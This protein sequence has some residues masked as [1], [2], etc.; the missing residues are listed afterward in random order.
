LAESRS[1]PKKSKSAPVKDSSRRN[2]GSSRRIKSTTTTATAGPNNEK[3]EDD[4]LDFIAA[5]I[6]H[7]EQTTDFAIE[8]TIRRPEGHRR[9]SLDTIAVTKNRSDVECG[10]GVPAA[11]QN[12]AAHH[13]GRRR[14]SVQHFR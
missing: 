3:T 6:R 2:K 4:V 10:T 13:D 8:F 9:T 12:A 7:L 11:G 1:S 5:Q 14:N